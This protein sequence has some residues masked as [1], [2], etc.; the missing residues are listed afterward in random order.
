MKQGTEF[1]RDCAGDERLAAARRPVQQQAAAQ[2]LVVQPPQLRVAQRGQERGLQA[3]LDLG[4][5][6]HVGE[7]E[8]GPL[9]VVGRPSSAVSDLSRARRLAVMVGRG[10]SAHQARDEHR[11]Q[12]IGAGLGFGL[13]PS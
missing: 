9:G 6:G 3:G 10:Y 2:A 4:H 5:P 8:A 7:L 1:A 12:Q 11:G 13:R